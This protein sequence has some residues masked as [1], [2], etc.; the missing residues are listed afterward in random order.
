MYKLCDIVLKTMALQIHFEES[1]QDQI[2][3]CFNII[4][5]LLSQKINK[6]RR[7][8][9]PPMPNNLPVYTIHMPRLNHCPCSNILSESFPITLHTINTTLINTTTPHYLTL[10]HLRPFRYWNEFYRPAVTSFPHHLRHVLH[11]HIP[12]TPRLPC[13]P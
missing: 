5:A 7:K 6:E 2:Q 13:F 9:N 12:V 8:G 3:S 1:E 10:Q 11:L 4:L